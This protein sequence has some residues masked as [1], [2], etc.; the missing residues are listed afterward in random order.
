MTEKVY[1]TRRESQSNHP[2]TMVQ[3]TLRLS[4]GHAPTMTVPVIGDDGF[5]AAVSKL[6]EWEAGILAAINNGL[7]HG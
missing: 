2:S 6:N 3:R 7:G 5:N 4:N 1:V